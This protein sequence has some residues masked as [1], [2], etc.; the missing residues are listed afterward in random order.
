MQFK[1]LAN[2]A[3]GTFC[4][5]PLRTF[6][7]RVSFRLRIRRFLIPNYTRAPFWKYFWVQNFVTRQHVFSLHHVGFLGIAFFTWWLG[8]FQTAPVQRRDRSR[9][10]GA[11]VLLMMGNAARLPGRTS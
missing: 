4:L 8:W 10:R 9:G 11:A 5:Q 3:H 2:Y 6:R 7:G 1:I